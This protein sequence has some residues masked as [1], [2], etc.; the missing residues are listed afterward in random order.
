[1]LGKASQHCIRWHFQSIM[2]N[3]LLKTV[4]WRIYTG[5]K[6]GQI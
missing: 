6:T 3:S 5:A 1:V 4:S 2:N